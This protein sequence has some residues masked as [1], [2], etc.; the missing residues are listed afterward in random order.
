MI[1]RL[2]LKQYKKRINAFLFDA[3]YQWIVA[4]LHKFPKVVCNSCAGK[5]VVT[6]KLKEKFDILDYIKDHN[7]SDFVKL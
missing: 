2:R 1:L 5:K 4:N 3:Y 6:A 7:P